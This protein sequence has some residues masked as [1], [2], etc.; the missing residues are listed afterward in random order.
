MTTQEF[1]IEFDILYNNL[2][3]NAAPPLN[4]YEKSVFLTKAQSD[5][6]LELYSGRNNL[7]L[8]FESSEEVSEYLK[9]LITSKVINLRYI[10]ESR[11]YWNLKDLLRYELVDNSAS[12]TVDY[13]SDIMIR[14]REEILEEEDYSSSTT[15]K[16]YPV[17]PVTLDTLDSILNN[18]FRGPKFGKRALRIDSKLPESTG[19]SKNN[20][21]ILMSNETPSGSTLLFKYRVWYLRYP[22][23]III[24]IPKANQAEANNVTIEGEDI[25]DSSQCELPA[26]LH[27]MILDR[28]VLYAKQAYIG[29][30]AQRAQQE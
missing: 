13:Q 28:A 15:Y 20:I 19:S 4:E 3:S 24:G 12:S 17:I 2:A 18:P 8:S 1:S 27:R 16:T 14:L 21:T 6:V 30:Q 25:T 22:K 10:S 23:P 11:D 5:I 9:P 7:G 29:G 26:S